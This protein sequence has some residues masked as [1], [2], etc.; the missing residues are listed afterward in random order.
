MSPDRRAN[1]LQKLIAKESFKGRRKHDAETVFRFLEPK[2]RL[3]ERSAVIVVLV[4]IVIIV[5][6]TKAGGLW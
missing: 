2:A 6:L 3:W 5:A 1:N 4:A